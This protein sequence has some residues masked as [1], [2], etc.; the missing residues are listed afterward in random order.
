MPSLALLTRLG[1]AITCVST[2]WIGLI[3]AKT[4]LER[5][6]ALLIDA[7]FRILSSADQGE[8]VEYQ[9]D[10]P[11]A[12]EPLNVLLDRQFLED[13]PQETLGFVRLMAQRRA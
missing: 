8:M 6:E 9:L 13:K 3:P 7:G 2:G 1:Y 11:D 5:F 10:L 4:M 12:F